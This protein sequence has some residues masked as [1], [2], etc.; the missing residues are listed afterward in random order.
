[1]IHEG[2]IAYLF[3]PVWKDQSWSTCMWAKAN[4][5]SE[6]CL[7]VPRAPGLVWSSLMSWTHWL[8]TGGGAGTPVASWI[9]ESRNEYLI[10]LVRNEWSTTFLEVLL[11]KSKKYDVNS[12]HLNELLV[13][14]AAMI[15][16]T[17]SL[18]VP[19]GG[20]PAV[21]W[22]GWASQSL[23]RVRHRGHKST[24]PPGPCAFETRSI[25]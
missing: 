8:P 22:A 1:M 15:Y 17:M 10:C 2:S 16:V 11:A 4:R 14:F 7:L 23:W 18:D 21:S 9:G 24:W 12:W 13:S 20:V 6:R 19:Q 5:M 3:S 25:W